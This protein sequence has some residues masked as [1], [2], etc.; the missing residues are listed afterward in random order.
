MQYEILNMIKN[1]C[2]LKKA[3]LYQNKISGITY[4]GILPSKYKDYFLEHNIIKEQDI[5]D[6][7]KIDT[8]IQEKYL[9][10]IPKKN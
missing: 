3:I 8:M 7:S 9:Q 5:L 4:T 10:Y 6:V 2:D 1:Y